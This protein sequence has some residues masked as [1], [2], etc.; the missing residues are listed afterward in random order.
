MRKR[1][2]HVKYKYL[3]DLLNYRNKVSAIHYFP[4]L[5]IPVPLRHIY[6]FTVRSHKHKH[7]SAKRRFLF[8]FILVCSHLTE[9]QTCTNKPGYE[10]TTFSGSLFCLNPFSKV[11]AVSGAPPRPCHVNKRLYD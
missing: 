11:F 3:E 8:S 4:P 7:G 10:V 2:T 9:N 6:I 5:T 1:N